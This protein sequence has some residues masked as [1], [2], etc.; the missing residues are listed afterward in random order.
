MK[1][2]YPFYPARQ[3]PATERLFALPCSDMGKHD[4]YPG[5]CYFLWFIVINQQHLNLKF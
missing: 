2:N 5:E 1:H 3:L 4:D